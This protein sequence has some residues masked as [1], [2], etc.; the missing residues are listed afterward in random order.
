MK[1]Y[2]PETLFL[3]IG[4]ASL[5]LSRALNCAD[6]DAGTAFKYRGK[7]RSCDWL[8]GRPQWKI[9]KIC[10][11]R[12]GARTN[13][14]DTCDSCVPPLS[15][16]PE[17]NKYFG[18]N[19]KSKM[20]ILHMNDHHSHLK[21][22]D[23]DFECAVAGLD[24]DEAEVTYGGFPMNVALMK[25]LSL[26]TSTIKVHAGDAITGTS[27]F[28]LFN[29]EADA[30]MMKTACFD[31]F[32]LGNHEFDKGDS[33]LKTFLDYLDEDTACETPVLGANIVPGDTSPLI[34]MIQPY[35]IVENGDGG[36]L[37]IIGIDIRNKTML[38]SQPDE[39][40]I[41]LEEVE[42][43]K[44]YIDELETCWGINKIMLFTHIGFEKDLELLA[45]LDGVDIIIGGD[46]HSLLASPSSPAA[47][48]KDPVGPYPT[49]VG[50]TCVVQAWEYAHGFGMLDVKFKDGIV[51][52]C[53]GSIKFP[54]DASMIADVS[55]EDAAAIADYLDS[56]DVFYAVEPDPDADEKLQYFSEQVAV[57]EQTVIATVPEDICFD[58]IPGQGKGEICAPEETAAQGGGVCN[59]VAKA[60]M[61]VTPTSDFGVQNAG[62]CRND[63]FAGDFTIDDAYSL[64][65]FSNTL[66]TFEM[67]GGEIISLL[68]DGLEFALGGGSTGAYPYSSGLRYDVNGSVP[69]VF[70][71]EINP[72]MEGEWSAIDT[73][74]TYVV[75]TNNYI[76]AGRDGYVTF[77]D[78]PE[79]YYTNT[80]TEYAQSFIDYALE[81]QELVDLPPS[82]YSTKSYSA[83]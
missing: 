47:L 71:V 52:K 70:N 49:K 6:S 28:S 16:P 81:M 74:T 75:V 27:F 63:I 10:Y 46:S 82:E 37:G 1:C 59:I 62:G 72:R 22:D 24:C 9:N 31:A 29:G 68:N 45:G 35:T 43:A 54:F 48:V 77:N 25:Q 73:D 20:S 50:N 76:A 34:G 36:A 80:Y 67:T 51:T 66:V 18:Q 3:L 4:A 5:S 56:T 33:G 26:Y 32:T 60:F 65:P 53:T 13:C 64:L 38:L 15:C 14:K 55:S 58:R 61:T 7:E 44:K 78:I 30:A 39:G 57:L 41:L 83:P 12:K 23:F 42:T 2:Y 69:E 19:K 79:E 17:A 21:A 40:T 8:S 11:K